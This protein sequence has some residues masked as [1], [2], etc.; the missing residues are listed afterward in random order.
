MLIAAEFTDATAPTLNLATLSRLHRIASFAKALK[1]SVRDYLSLQA[2]IGSG[3]FGDSSA[4]SERATATTLDFVH[5][6]RKV[7]ASG[8]PVAELD[9]LLRH[10]IDEKARIAPAEQTISQI[11][12]DIR[13]GL[14]KIVADTVKV[15]DLDGELTRKNLVLLKW[16]GWVIDEAVATLNGSRTYEALLEVMPADILGN[17]SPPSLAGRISYDAPTKTLRFK[18]AMT[19]GEKATLSGASAD[20]L[21]GSAIDQLFDTPRIFV[22]DKMK[23]FEHPPFEAALD[24]LPG[25]VILPPDLKN[26]LYHDPEGKTLRLVGWLTQGER[27]QLLELSDDASY[28]AAVDLLFGAPTAF[29]PTDDNVFLTSD[30]ASALFDETSEEQPHSAHARFSVVLDVL[31]PYVRRFLSESLVTQK[32]GDALGLDAE[33]SHGLL[34]QWVKSASLAD[35][36]CM[37]DFLTPEFAESHPDVKLT[38]AAFPR[39]FAAYVRLHKIARLA[40]RLALSAEPVRWLYDSGHDAG[41]LNVNDLPVA[42]AAADPVLFTQ[43]AR[44]ARGRAPDHLPP[45]P[46]SSRLPPWPG[47]P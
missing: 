1:L 19:V 15:P 16:D 39:Q 20:A 13:I 42:A 31:L 3:L 7:R 12:S 14:Q 25:G 17:L 47:T 4:S 11:L 46:R 34:T 41:W 33:T 36:T 43:W 38:A 44:P 24:A 32:V 6:V 8:L 18:G 28:T 30:A 10:V 45:V 40:E 9:Y 21:Y 2:L 27:Q 26:R 22:A 37:A 35:E 29:V 23:A 5:T